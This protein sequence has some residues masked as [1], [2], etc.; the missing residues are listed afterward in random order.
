MIHKTDL[1]LGD[2]IG[3][4]AVDRS[5]ADLGM[6]LAWPLL[7]KAALGKFERGEGRYE[8]A[9]FTDPVFKA[10]HQDVGDV[11][12]HFLADPFSDTSQTQ[13]GDRVEFN[14]SLSVALGNAN[15]QNIKERLEARY[16]YNAYWEFH[17][18]LWW[19]IKRDFGLRLGF[20]FWDDPWQ[21]PKSSAGE[22][23]A[24][25]LYYLLAPAA[26]GDRDTVERM[27]GL[28][29][30]LPKAVPIGQIKNKP[31]TWLA[32]APSR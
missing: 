18:G 24:A 28:M 27:S 2:F 25:S 4:N 23:L 7:Q 22:S 19:C 15:W 31:G 6:R 29:K 26:L 10:V 9:M 5:V 30:I 3:S 1:S 21:T 13:Y 20:E 14:D 16:G 12:I 32:V 17:D 8:P 11:E